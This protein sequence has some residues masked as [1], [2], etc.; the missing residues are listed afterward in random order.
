MFD[1][2]ALKQAVEAKSIPALTTDRQISQIRYSPDGRFLYAAG[3]DGLVHRW[4]ITGEQPKA[5]T[6]ITGHHGWVHTIA[7]ASPSEWLLSA[8]SWGELRRT[9]ITGNDTAATWTKTQ[10]HDGWITGLA[11]SPDASLVVTVGIDRSVRGWNTA[12]GEPRFEWNYHRCE[13][14]S[15]AFAPDGVSVFTGDLEGRVL[16][17]G[18]AD[19][20]VIREFDA[21]ALHLVNRL[22]DVG[23]ARVLRID[24]TGKSLLVAGTKPKNGGNVQGIPVVLVFRIEDGSLQRSIE[25]GKEG[26]VYVTDLVEADDQHWLASVSGNPGAGKLMAFTTTDDKPAFETTKFPNCHSVTR[27]PDGRRFAVAA[28]NAG[29]NGNG[30]PKDKDGNY[31]GNFSPIHLLTL[32]AMSG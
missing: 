13:V 27:H 22:Q 29:S 25:L 7:C 32:P 16:Q 17:T 8:D 18:V 15:V 20:K 1:P 21:S 6:P 24:L 26:D 19:G 3:H 28:T 10:A 14:F 2:S 4:D 30:R 23:G 5:L 12:T 9:D 31:P 11:I